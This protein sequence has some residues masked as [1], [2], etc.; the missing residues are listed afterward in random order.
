M[1]ELSQ[2]N[3]QILDESMIDGQ[4][5]DNRVK[6][7]Q[8]GDSDHS[9]D[10]NDNIVFSDHEESKDHSGLKDKVQQKLRNQN[11]QDISQD[12]DYPVHKSKFC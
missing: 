2:I 10:L 7:D 1:Y 3:K 9:R 8:D 4:N 5:V 11:Q 6:I 12:F